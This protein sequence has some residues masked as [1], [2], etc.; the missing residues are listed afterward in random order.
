[1]EDNVIPGS[2]VEGENTIQNALK[3]YLALV[4][5]GDF[6]T[7]SGSDIDSGSLPKGNIYKVNTDTITQSTIVYPV[8]AVFVS[9]GTTVTWG[10]GQVKLC[11]ENK[12]LCNMF[13]SSGAGSSSAFDEMDGIGYDE[14]DDQI[15]KIYHTTVNVGGDGATSYIEFYGYHTNST[16]SSVTLSGN[17]KL[18]V[19]YTAGG[20]YGSFDENLSSYSVSTTLGAY[21]KH[22]VYWKISF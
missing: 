20:S 15:T 5:K 18:G 2:E 11:L 19:D 14:G 22:H 13:S 8:D 10:D 21:R 6:L 1:L 17:L 7:V 9:D 4:M 3:Y 16:A 12:G